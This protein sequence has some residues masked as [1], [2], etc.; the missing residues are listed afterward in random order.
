MAPQKPVDPP[1]PYVTIEDVWRGALPKECQLVA[2]AAGSRREVVWCTAL[3]ARSPALTPLRGG[4]L[5][6]INPQVLTAVDSRLTLARLLES[7]AGQGVAGAAVLGRVSPDA[8]RVADANGLPLF[9]LPATVPL[10]QVE[11]QVLRYI[12]DRRAELHERAQD[13]HRQLSELALAGRGLPALLARLHELTGVP[14]L[15]E[16]ESSIDYVGSGERLS[17]STSAAIAAERPALEEWLREVPLSAFDPPVALRPLLNGQARLIAPILVQGSIA[18]FLSLLGTDGELGELHRLAVGRAAHACA[19]ELVRA[20]AARDA[21]DEVEEELLD[22]LTAGRPG[23]QQAARERA[24][25]KGFDVDAPYLVIAAESSEPDRAP[26]IRLAWERLLA[27]MRSS[28]LVRARG[29]ATL[30]VVSL[31]GRRVMEPRTLVEQL[32]RAARTAAAVPVA[33]GYGAVRTGTAEIASS[34]REAEQ[35]LTMGR[36]LFGPDSATAFADLGLYR[37]LYALQPLP[38]LRAFRDDA[39]TRLRAKDRGGVL[40]RT[41]GAY[42]A[43]NGS[44]TD[45]ADRLHLHRNTVLY[46]LGRIE[47][48]LGVNLRNAE[49][50][51]ALHLALKIGEVLEE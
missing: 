48:L 19:I 2:G 21:R 26:K 36:R 24:K 8:R 4:E 30:A 28:A 5:L 20:R 40:L 34:A 22:V 11:Q 43:T 33:V 3:R 10:D 18:G 51:L 23:S 39:L 14:V 37:L 17:E 50:R 49:V 13:L 35:A 15:L 45:A 31:A 46:R 41:L 9:A 47:D 16:R 29:D 1:H 38:E 27:T 32:H 6:L 12:V 44:P 25:R 42:L 7:L